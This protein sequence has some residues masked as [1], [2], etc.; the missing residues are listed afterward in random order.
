MNKSTDL[1]ARFGVQDAVVF[2]EGPGGLIIIKVN[3]AGVKSSI[4]LEGAQV[5]TW[6]PTGEQPVVWVSP[7]AKYVANKSVRGGI[8]ICWPWFGPHG[9]QSSYPAHGVARTS[10]WQMN[11]VEILPDGRT[12]LNFALPQ[13][14]DIGAYWP[15]ATPLQY[16]V[17]I[18]S[19][20]ELELITRN[21]SETDITLGEAL[22]TY[23]AVSDVRKVSVSGLQGCEYLDKVDGGNRK[24]QQGEVNIA[25]EVDRVYLD[26]TT[27]C[28][29]EDANWKRRIHIEKQGSRSTVVWNPWIEKGAKL[30]DLGETGYLNMLCVESANA[31]D[32]VVTIPSGG[33]HRLWLKYHITH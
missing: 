15:Y 26:T 20:L 17:T 31:A 9:T 4:T 28:I 33:E 22:H 30:G 16:V 14:V 5:L 7:E 8:P 13:T 2:E 18:G 24:L 21:E 27:E 19:S 6:T 23:F 29:I 12:Q 11:S 10:I 25:G 3:N 1:N 32:D